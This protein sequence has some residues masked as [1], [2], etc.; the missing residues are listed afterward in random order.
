MIAASRDDEDAG[1]DGAFDRGADRIVAIR[2]QHRRAKRQIDD[3]DVELGA[4]GN[5]VIE[6]GN[7][8]ADAPLA[9]S[10]ER[11]QDHQPRAGRQARAC[12]ARIE[13]VARDDAGHMGPVAIVVVRRV[14]AAHEIDEPIDALRAGQ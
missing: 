10:I 3:P 11:F 13:A 7:H 14:E 2:L 9:G 12:A 5:G 8:I 1:A 4:V 6:R